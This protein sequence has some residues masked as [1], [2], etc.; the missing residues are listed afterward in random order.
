[1]TTI[2]INEQIAFLR[3]QKGLTQEE[4]ANAL[5]VTN[6]AVSKW[7]SAQCC[8]DIQLLPDI[9]KL[10]DVSVDELLGYKTTDGLGDICLKIKDYFSALPEKTAFE[11][12]YRLAALL[13][14]AAS[15]DGY[16]NRV[17]WKEKDYSVDEVSSWGLSVCSEPE[18]ST[19]RKNNSIFFALGNGHIPPNGAQMRDLKIT[20]EQFS[21][22]N[23]LKVLYALYGL[24]L[25]DFDLYVTAD[26]IAT[27]AHLKVEDVETAIRDFPLTV[28]EED[29]VFK[30]RLEGSFSHIPSLLS[31][32]YKKVPTFSDSRVYMGESFQRGANK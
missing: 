27:A 23:V 5:G 24:T 14:E 18:G 9:A 22:L 20:M 1:M 32:F 11:N 2:K 17:P 28:K 6:Q 31:F 30:Y 29:G 19:V 7:E 3:K 26:E 25:S 21:N 4:L 13:H 8:P 12:A 10:F 16:K 15:T